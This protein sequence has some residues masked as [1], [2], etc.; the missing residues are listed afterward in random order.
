MTQT[1]HLCYNPKGYRLQSY[2]YM[3]H[4][5]RELGKTSDTIQSKGSSPQCTSEFL[6]ELIKMLDP[7]LRDSNSTGL[8]GTQVSVR[9][10]A[11]P[12]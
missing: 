10:N 8:G 6:G 5:I 4:S 11:S 9:F 7:T 1:A 2:R 12:R 3:C